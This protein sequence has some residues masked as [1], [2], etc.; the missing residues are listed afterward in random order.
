MVALRLRRQDVEGLARHAPRVGRVG[1]L[2]LL[3][4]KV[5]SRV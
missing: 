2:A 4:K 3:E 5:L 1:S